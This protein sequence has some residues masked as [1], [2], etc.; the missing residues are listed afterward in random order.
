MCVDERSGPWAYG[1]LSVMGDDLL[2]VGAKND[3]RPI[4]Q[5]AHRGHDVIRLS[6]QTGVL[7]THVEPEE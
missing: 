1:L 3:M 5:S 2:I 4:P 6:V 7:Q